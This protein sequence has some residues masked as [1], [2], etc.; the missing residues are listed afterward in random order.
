MTLILEYTAQTTIPVEIEGF[1]PA[2]LGG[3][4]RG[5]IERLEVLHGNRRVP[6]ADLFRVSGDAA[7]GQ[8]E[9]RGDL[10]GV[11]WIGAGMDRGEIRVVGH[12]GR[13]AGSEMTGGRLLVEGNAGDW[14]GAEMHGGQIRVRGR[15]GNLVGAAYRGS[16]SGMT[17]GTILVDGAVGDE[18]GQRMRRG[19]IAVGGAGDSV[20]F[21]MLA[22]SI[23]VFGPCGIRPGA[24]MRRGTI[25]IFAAQRPAL[26]PTFRYGCRL[27]PLFLAMLLRELSRLDYPAPPSLCAADC[28]LYHG[29]FVALGRGEVLLA[30]W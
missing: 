30:P 26:L 13:H 20:G 6:L 19:L 28:E 14:L 25:A 24:G 23:L 7:D 21:G 27:R 12:A 15:A 29:D 4:S 22:G 8:I 1:I 3:K 11:H 17:G 16:P 18:T 5:D 9:L 2:A 10:S